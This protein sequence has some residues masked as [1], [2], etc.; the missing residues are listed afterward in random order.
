MNA[1]QV[2]HTVWLPSTAD[3]R[4]ER[5]TEA[6]AIARELGDERGLVVCGTLRAGTLGEVGLVAEMRAQVEETIADARRLR[7][8]YGDLVLTGYRLSWWAM[9]G[10]WDECDRGLAHL[11]SVADD[12]DHSSVAEQVAVARVAIAYWSDRPAEAVEPVRAFLEVGAPFATTLAVLLWRAGEED[13]AR[14]AYAE[15]GPPPAAES[16]VSPLVWCHAAELAAYLGD[17]DL[18]GAAHRQLQPWSGRPCAVGVAIVMAPVD[19]YLALAAATRGRAEEAAAHAEAA[20]AQSEE[21]GTP[22]VT[23]WLTGLRVRYGF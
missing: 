1:H 16:N 9:A 21:W 10:A 13:A 11:A 14:R 20:L 3:V 5:I 7:I 19:A 6:L 18:A 2:G 4:L 17:A 22:V 12:L 15:A 23:D 8:T